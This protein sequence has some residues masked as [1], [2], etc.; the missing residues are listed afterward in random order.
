MENDVAMTK[1]HNTPKV[2]RRRGSAAAFLNKK[3]E[4]LTLERDE[5]LEQQR[6]T[7]EVLKVISR[8]TIDLQPVLDT[9]VESAARLC[10]ADKA[11]IYKRDGAFLR[12]AANYNFS[13]EFEEFTRQNPIGPGRGTMAGRVVLEGK[14]VHIPDVLADPDYTATKYQSR[15][16]YRSNLGVPL[17]RE[18]ET[19]G[20]FTLTRSHV[21]PYTEKQIEL[22][23]TF[24]D[25][26][27]IAIENARLFD[28]AK[29][30][31]ME[32]A[33]SVEELRALGDVSQA[34]NSTIDLQTVLST[35]I[36]KAVQLSGTDA[37]TI[38]A[39]DDASQEFQLRASY[40]MDEELVAAI[41]NRNVRLGETLI[42]R[43]AMQR[44]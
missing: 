20:V 29:S 36:S 33:R 8:S 14:T 1:R 38:Y 9:L 37:G 16:E 43:A 4:L 40:G 23:T 22:A 10:D 7:S 25:Q 18:G 27:V 42:S 39:F 31:T 44:S 17:L 35:I 6:A 32:L 5:A 15:G 24:A 13:R 41:I 3:V 34:V 2:A 21:R 11:V 12:L 26:A 28:E 19:I 30:R